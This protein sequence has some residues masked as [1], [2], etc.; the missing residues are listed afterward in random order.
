MKVTRYRFGRQ[1]AFPV[2]ALVAAALF[3]I[4][5]FVGY[6]AARQ[7]QKV[8]EQTERAIRSGLEAKLAEIGRTA[9]DYAWWNDAVRYLDLSLDPVWADNNVGTYIHTNFGYDTTYVIGRDDRVRYCALDG[10]RC[11]PADDAIG[12]ELRTLVDQARAT[13]R[14]RPGSVTAFISLRNGI[15]MV[16]ASPVTTQADDPIDRPPDRGPS[17]STRST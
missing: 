6:S 1:V 14:D 11:Q 13:P 7:G 9:Q 3:A 2:A 8:Q 17:S 16:G 5:L 10:Q 4:I 12:P 15:A